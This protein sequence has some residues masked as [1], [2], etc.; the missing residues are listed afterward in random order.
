M[1]RTV[2]G[3]RA[4]EQFL[5]RNATVLSESMRL[6]NLGLCGRNR[7]YCRPRLSTYLPFWEQRDKL[8]IASK[9]RFALTGL[10]HNLCKVLTQSG[11]WHGFYAERNERRAGGLQTTD[12]L[13]EQNDKL[14]VR[15]YTA[16]KYYIIFCSRV[17]KICKVLTQSGGFIDPIA[18]GKI[19]C[20]V[21]YPIRECA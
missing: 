16:R 6:A 11:G 15:L 7:C 2:E 3:A 14:V 19:L 18:L 21:P 17:H 20:R 1:P 12:L 5:E 9:F 4:T 8:Y 13:R 10:V